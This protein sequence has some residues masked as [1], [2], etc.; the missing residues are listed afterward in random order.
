M[1]DSIN[2]KFVFRQEERPIVGYYNTFVVK[3]W[4]DDHGEMVRGHVQHV[5]SQEHTYFSSL[6]NMTGFV[7]S[8]LGSAPSNLAV[9]DKRRSRLSLL[10]E[11]LGEMGQ[12]E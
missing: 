4:C 10:A 1:P 7:V 6:E 5:S 11:N 12:D 3:I 2:W 8:H 9:R